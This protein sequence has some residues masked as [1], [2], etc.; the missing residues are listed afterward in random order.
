MADERQ[1]NSRLENI[2][3][4]WLRQDPASAQNWLARTTLPEETKQRI[5]KSAAS[6]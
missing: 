3:N 4:N 5:L 2:A 1:R 6:E